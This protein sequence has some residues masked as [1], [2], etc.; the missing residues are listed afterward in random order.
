M[1]IALVHP[2]EE[3]QIVTGRL[4][5]AGLLRRGAAGSGAL[6][7]SGSAVSV[8]ATAAGA[9][10]LPDNDLTYLRLLVGAELLAADFQAQAIA[11][12]KLT[13]ALAGATKQMLADEKAHYNSLS[14]LITGAG[15]VPATSDD[16]NFTYPK[17]SFGTEASM[18]KLAS[19]IETLTLGAYL[20]AVENIQTAQLRLPIGQIAA[21][22]AQHVS[23]MAVA[24]GK[25][26]IG[27]AFA[28]ALQIDA[29]SAALDAYE[30]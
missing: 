24:A 22:E 14:T 25:P 13:P 15:Q 29:V 3:Q 11:S 1:G 6:L 20:G 7:L 30:S 2:T 16:I 19:S 12:G 17:R 21:N 26:I 27:R 8:F 28:P 9:A 18:L 5:R 10:T 4:S 23:A